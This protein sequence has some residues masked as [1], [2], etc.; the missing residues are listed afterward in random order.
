MIIVRGRE[1]TV[2]MGNY[3]SLKISASVTVDTD[4]IIVPGLM[5]EDELID[6]Y[7]KFIDDKLTEVLA[8]DVNE[9]RA[10]TNVKDSY[11]LSWKA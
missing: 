11:I 3:E 8:G 4:T 1:H 6:F 2:N 5:G 9:A 7:N 10:L